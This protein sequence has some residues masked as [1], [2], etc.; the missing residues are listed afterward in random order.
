M[1]QLQLPLSFLHCVALT[2]VGQ[3][4]AASI[5]FGCE[6]GATRALSHNSL[7][8]LPQ[9]VVVSLLQ[10]CVFAAFVRLNGTAAP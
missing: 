1:L 5:I 10:G 2:P 6:L 8:E 4:P 3:F 9:L 7:I